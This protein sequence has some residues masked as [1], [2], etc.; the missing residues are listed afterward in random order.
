MNVNYDYVII[1]LDNTLIDENIYLYSAF[2]EISM[3]SKD[4][5]YKLD[6]IWTRFLTIGRNNLITD[7]C[8]H[9]NLY[10]KLETYLDILRNVKIDLKIFKKVENFIRKFN[11]KIFIVTNGNVTQQK[12]KIKNIKFQFRYSVIYASEFEKP[13]PFLNCFS[14]TL[15]PEDK[16][17]I[18]GDNI[19]DYKFAKNLKSDFVHV[20]FIRNMDGFVIHD[21]I[22]LDLIK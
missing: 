14:D 20:K 6:W 22:K 5:Q 4:S 17:L 19:I 10:D 9:F 11:S 13:K 15:K 12:N 3:Q 2:T 7:Y 21:T 16:V 1:D 18:V 8:N